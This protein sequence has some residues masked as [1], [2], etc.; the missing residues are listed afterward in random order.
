MALFT[1]QEASAS[2]ISRCE[3]RFSDTG[4][5]QLMYYV[6]GVNDADG[7][8]YDWKNRDLPAGSDNATIKSSIYGH[9]I[10]GVTKVAISTESTMS[11]DSIIGDNP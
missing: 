11:D 5:T 9:L 4:N 7:T 3:A 10:S 2:T 1:T 8:Y 6:F